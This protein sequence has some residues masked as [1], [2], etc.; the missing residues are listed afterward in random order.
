M[1]TIQ[2]LATEAWVERLGLT[3]LHFLWQG[4]IIVAIYAAV[5]HLDAR[6]C[7]ACSVTMN[8]SD[9][10]GAE[11]SLFSSLCGTRGNGY[12]HRC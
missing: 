7:G 10:L 2:M 9:R 1:N 5:R 4:L 11:R 3:L 12:L 8:R 6:Q